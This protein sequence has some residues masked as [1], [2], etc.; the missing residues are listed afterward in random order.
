MAAVKISGAE[1]PIKLIF[2]DQFVFTIPPYQRPYSWTQDEV[3][4]LL[5]DL[6]DAAGQADVDEA[7]PYFL[8]AIVL[9]KEE[10]KPESEVIDGQQRLITLTILLSALAATFEDKDESDALWKFIAQ[11]GNEFAETE[12]KMRLTVRERD[13]KFFRNYIQEQGE[14]QKLEALDPAQLENDAQRNVRFNALLLRSRLAEIRGEVRKNLAKFVVQKCYLVAVST[15]DTD[16]AFRIFSVLNNRGIDLSP[17]D[18]FKSDVLGLIQ[19]KDE[20]RQYQDK[21]ED[22]EA[23]LGVDRFKMLFSHIRTIFAGE[24]ARDSL[25][26]EFKLHVLDKYQDKRDFVD[27]VLVPCGDVYAKVDQSAWESTS[28]ADGINRW[29]SWL[30]RIDNQDWVPPAIVYLSKYS[31]DAEK[32][33]LFLER[34]ERLAASMFVRRCGINQRIDR[35]ALVIG[36]VDSPGGL[37]DVGSALDLTNEE[38]TETVERLDGEIYL[39][40]KTR[41]YILERLDDSLSAGGAHYDHKIIT[42]EHVLPQNPDAGSQWIKEFTPAERRNWCHRLANLV[43]LPRKKNSQASNFDF[44]TKKDKY[45]KGAGGAAPFLLTQQVLQSRA[46]NPEVLQFRQVALL[47]QLTYLWNL[48]ND[49]ET[50]E[51]VA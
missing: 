29:L 27:Q 24:K 19:D 39:E 7:N 47:E 51:T 37:L 35:Y 14:L 17:A 50:P 4:E 8:G 3:T 11:K 23:E 33:C 38:R 12:N 18:I 41:L 45:F 2:D 49:E 28:H 15:P 46:W 13:A 5:D 26:R 48:Q 34:L 9:A 10:S 36:E 21:W 16:S 42:V 40:K 43:L 31:N 20:Q 1:Y 44:A 25:L 32:I 22:T 6:L 30:N